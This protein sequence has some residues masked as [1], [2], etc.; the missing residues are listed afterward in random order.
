MLDFLFF[1]RMLTPI[2]I[3]VLFWATVLLCIVAAVVNFY[4]SAF[5]HGLQ[6]L[7]LGPIFA[8]IFCEFF[9]LFF[10]MNE[11]LT[12]LKNAVQEKT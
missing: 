5:L 1:R 12:D 3:Q 11:T 4:H 6:I 8:R 9:I 2:L 10:R 7:I